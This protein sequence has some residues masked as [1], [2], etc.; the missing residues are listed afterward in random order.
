MWA[1]Q[2]NKG[3]KNIFKRKKIEDTRTE[4]EII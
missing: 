1:I 3:R 4:R 2:K